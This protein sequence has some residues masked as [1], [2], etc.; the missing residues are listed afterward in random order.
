MWRGG[1]FF[2]ML[3]RGRNYERGF[4]LDITFG[5]ER[6]QQHLARPEELCLQGGQKGDGGCVFSVNFPLT[7]DGMVNLSVVGTH[8]G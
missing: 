1:I 2:G 5:D 8:F 6:N 7:K 3:P 4:G